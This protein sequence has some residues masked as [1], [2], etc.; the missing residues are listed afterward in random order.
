VDVGA[1]GGGGADGRAGGGAEE[2]VDPPPLV[3]LGFGNGCGTCSTGDEAS[4][5]EEALAGS[6]GSRARVRR[7]AADGRIPIL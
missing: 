3:P 6:G 4:T 1:D 7:R 2:D 5:A